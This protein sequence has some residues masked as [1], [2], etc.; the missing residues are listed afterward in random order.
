M[1]SRGLSAKLRIRATQCLKE[2]ALKVTT[3]YL[4]FHTREHRE[5][6]HITPQI[7]AIVTKSGIKEGMVLVRRCTLPLGFM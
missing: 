4:K 1:I 7:E 2:L 3:E 6:I 5:Y